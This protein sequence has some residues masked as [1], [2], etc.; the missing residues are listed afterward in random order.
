L[1]Q[2]AVIQSLTSRLMARV[3]ACMYLQLLALLL[4]Q[5]RTQGPGCILQLVGSQMV[6]NIS[7]LL[8]VALAEETALLETA[9]M[10][11][12][13]ASFWLGPYL[14]PPDRKQ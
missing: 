12:T 8:A 13:Q 11:A 7:L 14:L 1:L 6:L 4:L 10:V 5:S 2:P 3:I 9:E